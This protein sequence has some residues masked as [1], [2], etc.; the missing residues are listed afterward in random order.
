MNKSLPIAW[1][2]SWTHGTGLTPECET[3]HQQWKCA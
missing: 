3:C 2:L 1:G